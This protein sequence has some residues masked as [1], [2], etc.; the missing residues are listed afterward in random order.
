MSFS[1]QVSFRCDACDLNFMISEEMELPPGWLGLQVSIA[2]TDGCVPD[3]EREVFC[4]FCTQ[5]CLTEYVSSPAMRE[6][7]ILVDKSIDEADGEEGE[8]GGY[9]EK[10]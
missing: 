10:S 5:D 7:L 6:R 4:H 2:D 3:H 9:E 1:H 8:G